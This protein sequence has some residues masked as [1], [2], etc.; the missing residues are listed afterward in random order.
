MA[1]CDGVCRVWPDGMSCSMNVPKIGMTFGICACSQCFTVFVCVA[2][3]SPM[4]SHGPLD[5]TKMSNDDVWVGDI[6]G[7]LRGTAMR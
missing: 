2:L 7:N 6:W 5:W 3:F 1:I 4:H